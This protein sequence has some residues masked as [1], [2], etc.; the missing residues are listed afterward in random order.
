MSIVAAL[1]LVSAHSRRRRHRARPHS[2]NATRLL[3]TPRPDACCRGEPSATCE[4]R[5]TSCAGSSR[6]II[7]HGTGPQIHHMWLRHGR[8]RTVGVRW[9][10]SVRLFTAMAASLAVVLI[11]LN[12]KANAQSQTTP[13]QIA[14][15]FSVLGLDRGPGND[16]TWSTGTSGAGLRAE[17]TLAPRVEIE[18][19]FTW[20]PSDLV[21][22][23]QAQGAT[24]CRRR[25]AFVGNCGRLPASRSMDSCCRV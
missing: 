16:G 21:Q 22:E 11:L 18:T 25:R 8:S 20:F 17:F 9:T 23:F 5:G 13:L 3:P 12:V 24:R 1:R 4:E 10:T 14:G 7:R 15:E 2:P 6:C 19:R